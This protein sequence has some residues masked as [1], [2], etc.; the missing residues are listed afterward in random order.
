MIPCLLLNPHVYRERER[1][2]ERS[3]DF[4]YQKG[5]GFRN[6]AECRVSEIKKREKE[7][8]LPWNSG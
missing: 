7:E 3:V 2:R 8:F 4:V 1:E 6:G 5:N